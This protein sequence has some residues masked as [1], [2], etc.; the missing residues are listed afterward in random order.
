MRDSLPVPK[1]WDQESL[2]LKVKQLNRLVGIERPEF[3]VKGAYILMSTFGKVM[4]YQSA[5]EI[6]GLDVVFDC[7]YMTRMKM[8]IRLRAYIQG[9]GAG[10]KVGLK[11]GEEAL[12][13]L[14]SKSI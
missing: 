12:K 13:N 10:M 7:G 5:G 2:E 9:I 8:Y 11:V 6:G 1:E 14:R 3:N 4:L